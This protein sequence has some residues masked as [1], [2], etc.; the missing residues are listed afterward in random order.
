MFQILI[1]LLLGCFVS[2]KD[3]K[4]TDACARSCDNSLSSAIFSDWESSAPYDARQ[5]NS[6][7]YSISSYICL[8]QYC[9]VKS[10]Q[11]ALALRNATCQD[12]YRTA[13]PP[14]SIL[15]EYTPGLISQLRQ[16][17]FNETFD[18]NHALGKPVTVDPEFFS[19]WFETLVCRHSVYL[20]N[21]FET[22][23]LQ[24]AWDYAAENHYLYR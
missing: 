7:L 19:S 16:I 21:F 2:A 22:D 13:L 23:M 1:V 6:R 3:I 12:K 9:P 14:L 8:S 5:C 20:N 11:I 17:R 4:P 15:D 18:P 24:S 10:Q